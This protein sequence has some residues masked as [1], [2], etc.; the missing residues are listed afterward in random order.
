MRNPS[1]EIPEK[2]AEAVESEENE[3]AYPVRYCGRY[4]SSPQILVMSQ[5]PAGT[6]TVAVDV[7]HTI[8]FLPTASNAHNS[9]HRNMQYLAT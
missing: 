1:S 4:L 7:S 6:V 3:A 5:M 8:S 2:P 9:I